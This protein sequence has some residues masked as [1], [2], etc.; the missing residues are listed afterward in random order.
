MDLACRSVDVAI[1]Y[2]AVNNE[3]QFPVG[4]AV[5]AKSMASQ[6]S[7]SFSLSAGHP[8]QEGQVWL[9]L[10]SVSTTQCVFSL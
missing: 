1:Q 6:S 8:A 10:R 5:I 2:G 9:P 4:S 3:I 7:K